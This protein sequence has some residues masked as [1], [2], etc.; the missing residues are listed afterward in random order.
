MGGGWQGAGG[1]GGQ[2]AGVLPQQGRAVKGRAQKPCVYPHGTVRFA[3][4]G[5][6]VAQPPGLGVRG[7]LSKSLHSSGLFSPFAKRWRRAGQV[8]FD[9]R[10]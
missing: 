8:S 6:E 2:R 7:A 10:S 3:P 9:V 1:A 4:L 5:G